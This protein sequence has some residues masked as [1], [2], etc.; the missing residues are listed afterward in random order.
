MPHRLLYRHLREHL[1]V[2][3]MLIRLVLW[4]VAIWLVVPRL[5]DMGVPREVRFIFLAMG[6]LIGV[7]MGP[8]L[9]PLRR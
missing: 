6:P 8:W 9:F 1:S 4:Y 7:A 3:R 2:P 5:V